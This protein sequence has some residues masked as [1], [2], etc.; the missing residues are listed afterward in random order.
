M[1]TSRFTAAALA[2]TTALLL[3]SPAIAARDVCYD[4]EDLNVPSTE[5]DLPTAWLGVNNA[6]VFVGIY[7]TDYTCTV[8]GGVIYDSRDGTFETFHDEGYNFVYWA[9]I[10]DRGEVAFQDWISHE[11][12]FANGVFIR[13]PSGE[14]TPLEFPSTGPEDWED[15]AATGLN[16]VGTVVGYQYNHTEERYHGVIW[17]D[18]VYTVY[19]APGAYSTQLVDITND[20]TVLGQG[21]TEDGGFFNFVD[22]GR[23]ITRIEYDVG[24]PTYAYGMNERGQVVGNY[25][26]LEEETYKNFLYADGV[27]STIDIEGASDSWAWGINDHGVIAGTYNGQWWGFMAWPVSCSRR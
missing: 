20:G 15:V 16:N 9:G 11:E 10:N 18:G 4:V 6:G 13:D 1:L 27:F 12:T 2:A 24:V 17:E 25:E 3:S 8:S 19:D 7:C 22:D 21:Y 23:D 26:D 5:G 14:I